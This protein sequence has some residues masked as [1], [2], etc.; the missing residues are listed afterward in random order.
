MEVE[1]VEALCLRLI[2]RQREAGEKI[3]RPHFAAYN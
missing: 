1:G 3:D 2:P